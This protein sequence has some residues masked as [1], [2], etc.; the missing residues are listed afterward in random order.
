MYLIS[1]ALYSSGLLG[2]A[3]AAAFSSI[4]DSKVI[5]YFLSSTTFDSS[6]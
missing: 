5:G 3:T 6:I 1:R 2:I 4:V